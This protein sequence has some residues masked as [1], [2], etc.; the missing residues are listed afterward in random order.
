MQTQTKWIKMPTQTKWIK[1]KS[2]QTIGVITARNDNGKLK[3]GWSLM[4]PSDQR[5]I[6]E[7]NLKRKTE[8]KEGL[9]KELE[10]H[11]GNPV[12]RHEVAEAFKANKKLVKVPLF[13]RLVSLDL[14]VK[15]ESD[16]I[17]F[18]KIPKKIAP[19]LRSFA[20]YQ[21]GRQALSKLA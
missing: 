8:W 4:C 19:T 2:N 14:A 11:K 5:A 18:T 17:D 10:P 21:L 3:F 20:I 12:K 1:D 7:E 9:M 6:K 13:S 16:K 15:R